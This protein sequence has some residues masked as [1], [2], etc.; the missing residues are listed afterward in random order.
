MSARYYFEDVDAIVTLLE[1]KPTGKLSILVG[2]DNLQAD[3]PREL[4]I[5]IAK[6][7]K[8]RELALW[9]VNKIRNGE[10]VIKVSAKTDLPIGVD[11][12]ELE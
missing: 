3:I 7:P 11:L 10:L 8:G 5:Q 9:T 1:S 6:K 2:S 12:T 4:L